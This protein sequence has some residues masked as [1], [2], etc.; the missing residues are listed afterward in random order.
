MNKKDGGK[1][2]CLKSTHTDKI[3]IGSTFDYL[4]SRFGKHKCDYKNNINITAKEIM[5]FDDVFIELIENCGNI[6]KSELRKKEGEYINNNN[7]CINK[8]IDGRTRKEWENINKEKINKYLITNKEKINENR[9]KNYK[10][11]KDIIL[12]QNKKYREN[13]K[14]KINEQKKKKIICSC[15]ISYSKCHEARHLKSKFH[16]NN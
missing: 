2:Y 14:E 12:E 4:S 5:K 6:D 15:G 11:K 1:I 9:R 10:E 3:Y 13:N 8:R 16:L 7:N